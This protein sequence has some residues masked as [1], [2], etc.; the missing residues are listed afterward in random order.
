MSF[1]SKVLNLL[2]TQ[3][4]SVGVGVVGSQIIMGF[5]VVD[6]RVFVNFFLV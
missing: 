1:K 3:C 5:D 4:F 2:L 6:F